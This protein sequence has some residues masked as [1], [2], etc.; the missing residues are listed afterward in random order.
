M[1]KINWV[2]GCQGRIWRTCQNPKSWILTI[3]NRSY[4]VRVTDLIRYLISF[5][6]PAGLGSVDFSLNSIPSKIEKKGE[7]RR[8]AFS[9]GSAL[10]SGLLFSSADNGSGTNR[11][12]AQASKWSGMRKGDWKHI[13]LPVWEVALE[14]RASFPQASSTPQ[15]FPSKVASC[16]H[17]SL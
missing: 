16:S 2:L 12:W 9:V 4:K 14:L 11:A 5:G 3:L 15:S 17:K 10:C 6:L 7:E 8:R 13:A 1:K